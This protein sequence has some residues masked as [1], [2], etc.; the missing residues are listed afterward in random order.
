MDEETQKRVN[1]LVKTNTKTELQQMCKEKNKSMSGTKID[2]AQRVL[3]IVVQKA[4]SSTSASQ[5]EGGST[6]GKKKDAFSVVAPDSSLILRIA[7][8]KFGHYTHDETSMVFDPITKRVI[9][10]QLPSGS[11]RS[12]QRIDIDTCQKFKFQY[13]FPNM[14]DPSPIYEVLENSDNDGGN[15]SDTNL[16]DEEEEDD[17]MEGDGNSDNDDM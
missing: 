1:L 12:L 3:G 14:L 9:G 17:E 10:V 15:K 16:S 11:V 4:V 8:N 5:D 7:K 13:N 6:A 2:M